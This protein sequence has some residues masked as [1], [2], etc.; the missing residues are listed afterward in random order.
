MPTGSI[1]GG[2]ISGPY[3][4]SFS[5]IN[6]DTIWSDGGQAFY[7]A[8]R[9][10]GVL[11]RTTNGGDNWFY[12]IPDTSLGNQ[13]YGFV[14]FINKNIGWASVS[15]GFAIHTLVGGDSTFLTNMS[16]LES[17]IANTFLLYQNYPN[18]FNPKTII[19]Y[20]L[21]ISGYVK[22]IIFDISGKE[23][24]VLVNHRQ[25]SGS[26]EIKFDGSKI[27]SGVYFYR[28]EAEDLKGNI[29]SETKKMILIR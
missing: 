10:R 24:A 2:T 13:G 17:K 4:F 11:Y 27:P 14:Q 21:R 20:E 25:T 26:Y 12:Q 5:N 7:G 29:E 15:H 22:L 3:A 1:N 9:Y 28:L 23:I 6:K 16:S 8:G 18:P 19:N